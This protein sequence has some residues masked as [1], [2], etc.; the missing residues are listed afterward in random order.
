[1]TVDN[2]IAGGIPMD[3]KQMREYLQEYY[4]IPIA[5][6]EQGARSV[7][8]PYCLKRHR[9]GPGA[10]HRSADCDD[11]DRGMKIVIGERHFVPNYGYTIYEYR[12]HGEVNEL[13]VP[14]NLG[15]SDSD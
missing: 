10:G 15:D 13:I 9:Q 5:L 7:S 8:C 4:G 3:L 1:M 14:E 12:A 2:S 6:R 11:N